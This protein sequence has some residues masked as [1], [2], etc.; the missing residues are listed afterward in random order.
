M[1]LCKPADRTPV[2]HL[3]REKDLL[4]VLCGLLAKEVF[5]LSADYITANRRMSQV[6]VR[7]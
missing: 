2:P 5:L 1:P 3:V 7:N 6:L 4:Q